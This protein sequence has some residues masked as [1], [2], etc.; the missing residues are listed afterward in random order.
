MLT[1]PQDI[2]NQAQSKLAQLSEDLIRDLVKSSNP[3][4]LLSLIKP[5]VSPQSANSI[6]FRQLKRRK[7][8]LEIQVA[9]RDIRSQSTTIC[10][11]TQ[12]VTQ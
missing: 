12:E 4:G 6:N 10:Q 3:M 7:Q 9:T 1:F 8:C 11:N 2:R 5:P